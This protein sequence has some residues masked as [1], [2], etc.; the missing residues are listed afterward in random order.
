[1]KLLLLL[2]RFVLV[3]SALYIVFTGLAWWLTPEPAQALAIRRKGWAEKRASLY[4][5][6]SRSISRLISSYRF[7]PSEQKLF[8]QMAQPAG[9]STR[10]AGSPGISSLIRNVSAYYRSVGEAEMADEFSDAADDF[11]NSRGRQRDIAGSLSQIASI[12]RDEDEFDKAAAF[13]NQA[14]EKYVQLGDTLAAIRSLRVLS[15][16]Y[17]DMGD[18]GEA[19]DCLNRALLLIST[20]KGDVGKKLKT[21]RDPGNK[22]RSHGSADEDAQDKQ[23]TVVTGNIGKDTNTNT[24]VEQDVEA[25]VEPTETGDKSDHDDEKGVG[26]DDGNNGEAKRENEGPLND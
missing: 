12:Y 13:Q 1:M 3:L 15:M 18:E 14:V 24:D 6:V 17:R 19:L 22:K 10:Q 4:S 2:I 26:K 16:S 23:A 25:P 9:Q 20:V 21:L 7:T 11:A 8:Q 5:P